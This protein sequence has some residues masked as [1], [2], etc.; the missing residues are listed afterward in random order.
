M[1]KVELF[2]LNKKGGFKVWSIQVYMADHSDYEWSMPFISIRHG[3]EGGVQTPQDSFVLDGKQ[4][5]TPYQQAVKEAEA[6]I[7]KQLDKNYRYTKEELKETPLLPMLAENYHKAGHRINWK[8]GVDIS[9]KLDGLRCLIKAE[10]C[11]DRQHSVITLS[12]RTGQPYVVPH[13][14]YAL[15]ASGVEAGASQDG[16]V[17]YHGASL[18]D[19]TSAVKRTDTQKE[20]DKVLRDIKRL[21]AEYRRP[22]KVEGVESPTLEEELEHA[23]YIHWLRPRL[24]IVLFDVPSDKVWVDRLE[25]LK[26]VGGMME[27][28]RILTGYENQGEFIEVLEY[29]RV[30]SESTMLMLH[31]DARER[32]FEGVMMRNRNGLYESGKRSADLQKYKS[33]VG[34]NVEDKDTEFLIVGMKA[35]KNGNGVYICKNNLNERTFSVVWG[36]F[37]DRLE[38]LNNADEIINKKFL[39]VKYQTRYDDTLLPQFPAGDGIREGKLINGEFVPSE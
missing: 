33:M 8:D 18:Q 4:G 5:R 27:K 36:S 29:T 39:K 31:D 16:E 1:N 21:G 28:H 23:E 30:Y 9:D 34:D 7:K 24:K 22:S 15:H 32:G 3:S 25:G 14:T 19:I 38:A 17:Y 10:Y 2:G 37:K 26:Q 6:K 12:S 11:H 13:I 20:I 35:D